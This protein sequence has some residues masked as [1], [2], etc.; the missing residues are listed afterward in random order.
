MRTDID[1]SLAVGDVALFVGRI[2]YRGKSGVE[3]KTA[4]GWV[5]VFREGKIIRF[6]AFREPAQALGSLGKA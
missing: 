4:A 2:H 1:D 6:R 5:L 3:T